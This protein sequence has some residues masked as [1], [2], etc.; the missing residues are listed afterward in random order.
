VA[1]ERKSEALNQT[2]REVVALEE[3]P[4]VHL[5]GKDTLDLTRVIP[6]RIN[7]IEKSA[8]S[9]TV[10]T[11]L[12]V[13]G[14][15]RSAMLGK[16][17]SQEGRREL[18]IRNAREFGVWFFD[19]DKKGGQEPPPGKWNPAGLMF[20]RQIVFL[21]L[22][23][24]RARKKEKLPHVDIFTLANAYFL[25]SQQW[26]YREIGKELELSTDQARNCC[27]RC[28]ALLHHTQV[29]EAVPLRGR[30]K[31]PPRRKR[32]ADDAL[33]CRNCR[34]L[35]AD[36][37]DCALFN[38]RQGSFKGS[39]PAVKL[40]LDGMLP[41]TLEEWP[42]EPWV[43]YD[44]NGHCSPTWDVA[45]ESREYGCPHLDKQLK[46]VTVRLR[47]MLPRRSDLRSWEYRND[48]AVEPSENRG[49]EQF[50]RA[51]W[52]TLTTQL[53]DLRNALQEFWKREAGGSPLS[54][55]VDEPSD[56]DPAMTP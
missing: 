9:Q 29:A 15:L 45:D 16:N 50:E 49:D 52:T 14:G 46:A 25:E 7:F 8:R 35:Q 31:G 24:L 47:E 30:T 23:Q 43:K 6:G 28:H 26:T 27:L 48:N 3:T 36:G 1:R 10:E 17:L 44:E 37:L 54:S 55:Q 13:L 38:F 22:G 20:D 56:D 32:L 2:T 34:H 18:E 39:K 12:A 51:Q 4:V 53:G 11:L 5:D 19:L 41:L 21:A 33:A 42:R 40:M